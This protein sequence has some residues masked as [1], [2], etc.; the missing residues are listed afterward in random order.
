MT[1]QSPSPSGRRRCSQRPSGISS[2]PR[3]NAAGTATKITRPAYGFSN[4]PK[5]AAIASAMNTTAEAVVISTPM[6]ETG[7]RK[8]APGRSTASALLQGLHV[9]D[10]R[11]DIGGGQFVVLREHRRLL[12]GL[13]L[14]SHSHGIGD[15]LPDV[16]GRQLPA[17]A[18]ERV[19]LVAFA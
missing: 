1:G 2:S 14:L 16:V 10:E 12:G 17:D 3:T 8:S 15:P 19:R 13:G 9:G 18:V 6:R 4:S 7:W 11:V 5:P